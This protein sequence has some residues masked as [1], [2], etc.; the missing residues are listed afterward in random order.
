MKIGFIGIGKLGLPVCVGIDSKGHDV[1]G[2]DIN[3]SINEN[4]KAIELL[5]TKENV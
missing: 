2:Y 1:I 3:P 4:T 5:K